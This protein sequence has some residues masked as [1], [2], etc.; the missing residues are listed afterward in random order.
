MIEELLEEEKEIL[1]R[2]TNI[3][4]ITNG[5]YN[6]RKNG[7]LHSKHVTENINIIG[8]TNQEGID[9]VIK[10]GT[11][12]EDVYIPV[13]VSESNITDKVYNDFHI[14][15]DCDITIYAGC[16]INNCSKTTSEHSGIHRFHVAKNAKVKYVENHF[17]TGS[18]ESKKI[19][20]PVTEIYLEPGSSLEM[21]TTQIEGVDSTVRKTKAHLKENTNLI[22]RENIKTHDNQFAKTIFDVTLNGENSSAHLISRAVATDNSVQEFH[23]NLTGNEKCYAHSEC[24]AILE[25]NAKVLAKPTVFANS[26]DATL[27]HEATIGKLAADQLAK[28]MTLGLTEKEAEAVIITGFLK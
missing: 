27:I 6:I 4:K 11:K 5:A 8:K 24:D 18:K 22:I 15:E 23:S 16:G 26:T 19:L 1:K 9:I 13:I 21:Y 12:N 20:N 28:L 3:N 2:I 7:K 10:K 17:G 14:E 25:G